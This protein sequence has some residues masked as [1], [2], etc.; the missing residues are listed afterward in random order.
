VTTLP[1][2]S[3]WKSVHAPRPLGLS[4]RQRDVLILLVM[5]ALVFTVTSRMDLFER[6]AR[7]SEAHDAW[8][9]DELIWLPILFAVAGLIFAWRQSRALIRELMGRKEAEERVR[10]MALHDPLTG[11]ANRRKL[12]EALSLAV[13]AR[14]ERSE[15]TVLLAIDLDRFKPI[16]DS[17]GHGVGDRL[18]KEVADRLTAVA[19]EGE[20]VARM[21]GDEFALLLPVAESADAATRPARRIIQ[22][23]EAPFRID[24]IVCQI[25]ASIGIAC[26]SEA[27]FDPEALIQR[28]DVA[29]YRSKSEGRGQFRFFE[30][31]MDG[32]IR[33]RALLEQQ[34]SQALAQGAIRPHYQPL[35]ELATGRLKGFE[36]LARWTHAEE[37]VISPE[38]FIPIA[39]DTGLIGELSLKLLRE[40]CVEAAGWDPPLTL[41][42]NVSPVQLR[43][44]RLPERFMQ[45]MT[46]TGF[47]PRRL[48]VEITENTLVADFPG[49]KR[50]LTALKSH[51]VQ[52]ALDDFGTGYSSLHHLRELPFDK[53]KIDRSFILSME[54]SEESR[55]IVGAIIG[56]GHSL[57]LTTL[58]EGI[59]TAARARELV[60]LG[61]DMGQ[62]YYYGRPA[63]DADAFRDGGETS[64]QGAA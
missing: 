60:D 45:V 52:I 54:E 4:P 56:L 12:Q 35:V 11:L 34:F 23:L 38:V 39:E 5:V 53:L 27:N 17:H 13:P 61:C 16:N 20:L 62:G 18:L 51:G 58:A 15:V 33:R 31:E 26:A 2:T 24:N 64:V 25:G 19:R 10:A 46:E 1:D 41:S 43:D 47:D 9:L 21:G 28:A 30:E 59:E 37:G 48:E 50:I 36:I 63:A 40:A 55:K 22:A 32:H 14:K 6:F 29:L 3:P 49:A 42:V 44:S 8:Q 7:F 57:G